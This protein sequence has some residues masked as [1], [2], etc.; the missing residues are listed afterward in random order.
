MQSAQVLYVDGVR[1]EQWQGGY[2]FWAGSGLARG[3]AL[4]RATTFGST[5]VYGNRNVDFSVN[6]S[7]FISALASIRTSNP[8]ELQSTTADVILSSDHVSGGD[9]AVGFHLEDGYGKGSTSESGTT[10]EFNVWG[11]DGALST[12]MA[13][14]IY[15]G[16]ISIGK[17]RSM[18][19]LPPDAPDGVTKY[20]IKI[21]ENN[22][23]KFSNEYSVKEGKNGYDNFRKQP[24]IFDYGSDA[25]IFI[26]VKFA[27]FNGV[28]G[29]NY[30]A[31][32]NVGF[33]YHVYRR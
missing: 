7:D 1:I 26:T 16:N 2:G 14:S 3:G 30:D 18:Y 23:I 17:I 33:T 10:F 21:T 12:L 6:P 31:C 22:K 20:I 11:P 32:W 15:G 28:N 9:V 13:N 5:G 25:K 24:L 29:Q 27:K 19:L 4:G 8:V